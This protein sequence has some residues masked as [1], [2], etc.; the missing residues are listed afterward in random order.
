MSQYGGSAAA[1]FISVPYMYRVSFIF[2]SL[3]QF[4]GHWQPDGH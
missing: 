1:L 3:I 2:V 4:V